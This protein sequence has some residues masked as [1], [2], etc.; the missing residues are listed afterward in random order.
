MV[1]VSVARRV[2]CAASSW[3]LRPSLLALGTTWLE[4]ING[5]GSF[6][7]LVGLL[8]L[9]WG[10][11]WFWDCGKASLLPCFLPL[12]CSQVVLTRQRGDF[13]PLVAVAGDS[14]SY[15]VLAAG[16]PNCPFWH[17]GF[18]FMRRAG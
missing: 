12:R 8:Q 13:P 2:Y 6:W 10:G 4:R 3:C 7:F 17:S 15:A 18:R 14:Y 16:H 9:G 5:G 11:W 1:A